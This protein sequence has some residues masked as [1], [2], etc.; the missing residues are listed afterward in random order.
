MVTALI[1]KWGIDQLTRNAVSVLLGHQTL[2]FVRQPNGSFTPPA[3]C[4]WTLSKGS[5]YALQQRHGN[6]FSFDSLGR[7]ASITDPYSQSLSVPYLSSTSN[8]PQT[9]TDWKG[10]SLHAST[11]RAGN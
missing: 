10:R 3:N 6:S 8:L 7:L 2:Q 4:T 9:V 11:T 5:T 1:A